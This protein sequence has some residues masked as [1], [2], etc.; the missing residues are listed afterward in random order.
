MLED[1]PADGAVAGLVLAAAELLVPDVLLQAQ[2]LQLVPAH[3]SCM[4]TSCTSCTSCYLTVSCVEVDSP[5]LTWKLAVV[6]PELEE[7]RL[8]TL[9]AL[10]RPRPRV[11][12]QPPQPATGEQQLE[13]ES[14][15]GKAATAVT[16][17]DTDLA[18][19]I[20]ATWATASAASAGSAGCSVK[21][22]VSRQQTADCRN[23][24]F[25]CVDNCGNCVKLC[26]PTVNFL[27][28]L[29]LG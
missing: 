15:S 24:V 10:L 21:C 7:A 8:V 25:C 22:K 17:L 23:V 4:D 1:V 26:D 12:L 6:S 3:T 20:A 18:F 28:P 5:V 2:Q 9:L 14:C 11:E 16:R 19:L 27:Q 29:T 13:L